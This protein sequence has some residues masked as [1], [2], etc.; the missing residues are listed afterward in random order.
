MKPTKRLFHK[1][2]SQCHKLFRVYCER[3]VPQKAFFFSPIHKQ[4]AV[5]LRRA[6][7][8]SQM[9]KKLGVCP[10]SWKKGR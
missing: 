1:V 7:V 6:G 2:T 4:A 10:P 5:M 8:W 9:N 3:A